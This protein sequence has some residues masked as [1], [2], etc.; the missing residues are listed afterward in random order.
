VPPEFEGEFKAPTGAGSDGIHISSPA[1]KRASKK[2]T[3]DLE[4]PFCPTG[5]QPEAIATILDRLESGRPFTVLRG[6]T[7]TG[8]TF[9]VA[10][11]VRRYGRPT[12]I[13]CHNKTLAA[14]LARELRSFFPRNSVE[15]FVSYYN[16]YQPEA[17][18]PASDT[19]IAKTS[20][21]NQEL[22]ALR[23]RATRSVFERGDVIVVASVSCIY[24]LGLPTNYLNARV[25]LSVGHSACIERVSEALKEILYVPSEGSLSQQ[26]RGTFAVTHTLRSSD[27]VVWPPYED[28]PVR[29]SFVDGRLDCIQRG[30]VGKAVDDISIYPARHHVTPKEQLNAACQRIEAE[31]EDQLHALHAADNP[32]AAARLQERTRNDLEMIRETGFCQ[33]ME[34]YSRHLAG[35]KQG[36]APDTFVDYLSGAFG[37]D[38]WL[39]VVDESHVT[40]PQLKGM[41]AADRARKENLVRHGFRLPSA[42]DNRPLND[43]EF[44]SKV[45]QAL[46][47]SATP[48]EREVLMAQESGQCGGQAPIVDMVIRP[49]SVLDPEIEVWPKAGQLD[50][51]LEEVRA[52]IAQGDKSLVMAITKKDAEDLASW[53]LQHGVVAKYLHSGLTTHERADV[54]EELQRGELQVLVGV[55]LLREGLDLPQV[56]LVVVMDADKEGF[57]RSSRSLIQT[58]GRAARNERGKAVFLADVVTKSMQT[59]IDETYRRRKKQAAYNAEHQLLPITAVG[60]ETRSLFD[61]EREESDS[62]LEKSVQ[63]AH[64]VRTDRERED[65]DSSVVSGDSVVSRDSGC[66]DQLEDLQTDLNGYQSSMETKRQMIKSGDET[67]IVGVAGEEEAIVMSE[68]RKHVLEL[69]KMVDRLP[70]KTGVYLWMTEENGKVLYVGKA[71]SLRTRVM[72][73]VKDGSVGAKIKALRTRARHIDFVLTPGGE[74]DALL[75]EGRLIKEHRPPYNVLLRDDKFYPYICVTLS[76]P[77]PSIF[78]VHRKDRA[79]A[80]FFGPYTNVGQLK[81]SLQLLEQA[82]RLRSLRFQA[83][84]GLP[85]SEAEYR[86]AVDKCVQVLEGNG[87]AVAASLDKEGRFD[88]AN[89]VR[90]ILS[91]STPPRKELNFL[92][93]P[94]DSPACDVVALAIVDQE[95]AASE[96]GLFEERHRTCLVQ[97]LQLRSGAIKGRFSFLAH[98]PEAFEDADLSE[99]VETVLEQYFLDAEHGDCPELVLTQ[100]PLIQKDAIVRLLKQKG[101]TKS[102]V[103]AGRTRGKGAAMDSRA[104]ELAYANAAAEAQRLSTRQVSSTNAASE[105]E[106]LLRLPGPPVRIEAY[107]ISHLQGAGTV[108]S[109]VVF[110][111]GEPAKELYRTYNIRGV[112]DKPDDYAAMEEVIYRRFRTSSEGQGGEVNGNEL[113][114]LVLV[115][116]GK[117]QLSAAVRGLKSAGYP[118][119]AICALA[120]REEELFVYGQSEALETSSEQAALLLLR[121]LRDESHRFALQAHRR[122]RRKDLLGEGARHYV[123]GSIVGPQ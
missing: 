61:I 18:L 87:E 110:I 29:L 95:P 40:L 52:R 112:Q 48:G 119:M 8:K 81:T 55:N 77:Y 50:A 75:L 20:S 45:E 103:R 56:S 12:L 26:E 74:H 51:L 91:C 109:R 114:D 64:N 67:A 96:G 59:C 33:G 107:D 118:G 84:H 120:K 122:R 78:S 80:R 123:S 38:G 22:D 49:T 16:F 90:S 65:K 101:G 100:L 83:R 66:A 25:V 13:L 35:R 47:V 17:F 82:F 68:D 3:F 53:L 69:K 1:V 97:L 58:V 39:L 15:L 46:F 72:S 34:N 93:W 9:A 36:D 54:L 88:A 73:Y 79:N 5:D 14:Q 70:T 102:K 19:Y 71:K 108:A 24:G 7:G 11:T 62:G 30:R 28:E 43:Q 116:G 104:I 37:R 4:A 86:H 41:Y 106:G 63:W 42:L 60:R 111:N 98:V 57:L 10:E 105:L 76:D 6:A 21:I 99:A 2:Y 115:D 44:W 32:S 92:G 89:A 113:P 94:E 23:H 27:I 117:G 31:L 121:A 85:V